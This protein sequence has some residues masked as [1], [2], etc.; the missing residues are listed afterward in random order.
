MNTYL[1]AFKQGWS[2]VMIYM[3][4]NELKELLECNE[5]PFNFNWFTIGLVLP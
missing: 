3:G 2:Y 4:L 5:L 1:D